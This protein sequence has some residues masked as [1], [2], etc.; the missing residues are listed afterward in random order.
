M[1]KNTQRGYMGLY[2]GILFSALIMGLMFVLWSKTS[3]VGIDDDLQPNN[4]D[5]FVPENKIEQYQADI[6]AAEAVQDIINDSDEAM[7]NAI[8]I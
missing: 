3:S 2:I 6:D 8:K 5:G 7:Q 4:I 1:D